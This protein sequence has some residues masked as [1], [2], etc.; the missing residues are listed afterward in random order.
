[1]SWYVYGLLASLFLGIYNFLYGLLDKKLQISTILIGIGTGIILTGI[2]YAVIVRKNIFEFNANWWLPSVI[3]LTIGIAIIFVIKSFS[4][5]KV[6][7]SQL[8]PLINTNT[9]FSVTLGLII[10]K[11]YQSVSLIK[12]LLGTLLI[13]L[14]AI[15]IK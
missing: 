9:L 7:V 6:K 8:V 2:I 5:P 14:G 11:E 12:V 1:M 4:D 3:G 10:F 15:V 13:L